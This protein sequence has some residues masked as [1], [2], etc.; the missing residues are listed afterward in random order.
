MRGAW[1]SGSEGEGLVVDA[2]GG[3]AGLARG[4]DDR[5]GEAVRAADVD[6]AVGEAGHQRRE[7]GA[8]RGGRARAGR[9]ARAAARRVAATSSAISSRRTRSSRREPRSTTTTSASA[10]SSSQ[11][12]AD[13]RDADP[14]ADQQ[15][16]VA[17]RARRR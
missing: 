10:G 2:V 11:Q 9:R 6:V 8:R 3:D 17:A 1:V 14:G 16:P 5:G 15:H 12:R 13:R 7:R 4:G